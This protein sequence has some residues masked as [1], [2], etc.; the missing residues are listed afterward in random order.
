M[1]G[2]ARICGRLAILLLMAACSREAPP[3]ITPIATI[4]AA[5]AEYSNRNVYV[6]GT[7]HN[8]FY[9]READARLYSLDDGSGRIVV[10]VVQKEL[11]REGD[12]ALVHGQIQPPDVVGGIPVRLRIV[13]R[14]RKIIAPGPDKH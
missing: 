2:R 11:P 13:E 6:R 1:L 10:V 9:L 3:V 7:V 12:V 8:P 5:R 14:E 4:A